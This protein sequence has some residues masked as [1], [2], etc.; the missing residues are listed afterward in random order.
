[1]K[2][3][4]QTADGSV[5]DTKEEASRHERDEI[6]RKRLIGLMNK[7]LCSNRVTTEAVAAWIFSNKNLVLDCFNPKDISNGK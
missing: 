5:F 7:D 4:W 6:Q 1:M 3:V 2:Q